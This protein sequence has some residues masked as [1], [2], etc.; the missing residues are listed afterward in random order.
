M[1][2]LDPSWL[3][4]DFLVK[5]LQSAEDANKEVEVIKYRCQR[6][7]PPGA[8][9][10]SQ[11]YRVSVEYKTDNV[12]TVSLIIKTPLESGFV[13]EVME[14]IGCYKHEIKMYNEILPK[15]YGLHSC[16]FTAKQ[17]FC[18]LENSLVLE[19]LR[20]SGYKMADR[21]QQLDFAHCHRFLQSLARLHALSVVTQ[22]RYP[23]L[24]EAFKKHP[25]LSK[26]VSEE[27]NRANE[28]QTIGIM[29]KL[30]DVLEELD[31]CE[32][33]AGMIR[34]MSDTWWE[35]MIKITTPGDGRLVLNHADTW[36]N[37]IMFKYDDSGHVV[38]AKLI[39]FQVWHLNSFALDIILFWWTSANETVREHHQSEL[40]ECYRRTFNTTLSEL[41]CSKC[42]S[43][44][45]FALEIK[46]KAPYAIQVVQTMLGIAMAD[47]HVSDFATPQSHDS[48]THSLTK[49]F[50]SKY[51]IK[52]LPK[53]VVQIEE[54]GAFK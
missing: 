53:I 4:G 7:V 2:I 47:P 33:Y 1:E 31:G 22:E 36:T 49:N 8:N 26:D 13:R 50:K 37:N 18:P 38:N 39:D 20:E 54:F 14:K 10:L 51:Y 17:F 43:K 46:S 19:D 15:M 25:L 40:F 6:A 42:L 48:L 41:Q 5:L 52:V 45:E 24:L 12:K 23:E 21:L 3:N 11:L 30:A 29:K 34:K 9:Y 27:I 32:R 28:E 44:E 35:K 16:R